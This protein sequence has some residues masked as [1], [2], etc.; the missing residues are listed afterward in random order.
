MDQGIGFATR[1]ATVRLAPDG[2]VEVRIA[3]GLLQSVEDAE[4][5]LDAATRA[6]GGVV[7]PILV[8]VSVAVPLSPEAR[9]LYSGRRLLD[10][11]TAL[12]LLVQANPLGRMMGNIYFRIAKPGIPIRL[13][14][15]ELHARAWLRSFR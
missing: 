15:N 3:A 13:F 4:T 1:T 11:F 5:N 10:A 12:A 8:D 7:R 14:N 6:G 2:I 9:R